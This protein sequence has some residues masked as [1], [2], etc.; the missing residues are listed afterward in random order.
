[1]AMGIAWSNRKQIWIHFPKT[2]IHKIISK[3]TLIVRKL[4]NENKLQQAL[5]DASLLLTQF[6]KSV[7]LL[8]IIGS[9]HQGI[10]KLDL[11][12][13]AYN[14]HYQLSQIMQKRTIIWP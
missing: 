2:Q 11:A 9:V 5:A 8:N 4:Y 14:K 6:P 1:M 12:I 13:E 3:K 7:N 10:G